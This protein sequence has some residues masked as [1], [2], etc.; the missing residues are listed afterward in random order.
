MLVIKLILYPNNG[1][2]M[3]VNLRSALLFVGQ[4]QKKHLDKYSL[5][6]WT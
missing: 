1:L 4:A 3:P 5:R 6:E 2:E